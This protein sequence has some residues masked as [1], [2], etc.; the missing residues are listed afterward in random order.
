MIPLDSQGLKEA[1]TTRQEHVN[2][3]FWGRSLPEG[4]HGFSLDDGKVVYYGSNNTYKALRIISNSYNL[5]YSVWCTNE[6]ELYDLTTDPH[7]TN[8]IYPSLSD[9][10]GPSSTQSKLNLPKLIPRLDALLMV[11][12]SCKGHTCVQPWS[13]LHPAGNVRTLDDALSP[14]F[15]TFYTE[16]MAERVVRYDKCELGYIVE[17]EGPQEVFAFEEDEARWEL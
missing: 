17:S 2:V 6:H 12:K 5:Y 8:N 16:E 3:E 14:R 15:D 13:V 10:S 1:E 9:T 7:Q 4:I 11:T